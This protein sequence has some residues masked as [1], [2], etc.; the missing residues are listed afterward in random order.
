MIEIWGTHVGNLF[1]TMVLAMVPV[2]ELRGAIPI[3]VAAGL[4]VWE[5]MLASIVGNM[6]PVPF[7]ILFVRKIFAWMRVKSPRLDHLVERFE[8]K[9]AKQSQVVRKYEWFG[10]VILVAIPLPGTGAWT[11][12]LVAAM[13]DMR[14]KR[15][16]P[17]V[18]IGVI[19]AG[20]IVS[21]ITY[22]AS[23]LI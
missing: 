5:A 18:L 6:I 20:F 1:M 19:I 13:L 14:L 3:G 23:M 8:R 7:I 12:A 22:G 11:G 17:A 4:D 21:Y 15:A 16:F 10:L 9:A 2:M